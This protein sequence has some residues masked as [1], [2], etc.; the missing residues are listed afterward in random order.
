MR[1][2][3]IAALVLAALATP[4]AAGPYTDA[5]GACLADNTT[6]R[7]R[8]ELARWIFAAMSSHPEMRDLSSVTAEGKEQV[9]RS[10]GNLV[11]RLLTENCRDPARA[12]MKAEGPSSFEAAFGTL[13]RLAMQELMS[14]GEVRTAV[15]SFER[16]VDRKK[17]EAAMR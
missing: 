10:A 3:I 4:A 8:K 5:L 16:Y 7:D 13:G 9:F 1:T 17:I 14:N 2:K 6:G 12:A 15:G 11:T